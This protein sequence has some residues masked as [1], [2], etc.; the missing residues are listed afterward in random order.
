MVG[1]DAPRW[2]SRGVEGFFFGRK[3]CIC[4]C[5]VV[6]GGGDLA[7]GFF[8]RLE[9]SK[10]FGGTGTKWAV[11]FCARLKR[12]EW[13]WCP[14]RTF[15]EMKSLYE[16]IFVCEMFSFVNVMSRLYAVV[17]GEV[18]FC[19]SNLCSS[20]S[21]RR[22]WHIIRTTEIVSDSSSSASNSLVDRGIRIRQAR[23]LSWQT[24]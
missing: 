7:K 16:T 6:A 15:V 2:G 8:G 22:C 17:I 14:V 13:S 24:F 21:C 9:Q 20:N 19:W 23:F 18:L 12:L 4:C 3:I 5:A 10:Q 11:S 1:V